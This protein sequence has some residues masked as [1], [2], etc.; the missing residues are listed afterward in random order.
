MPANLISDDLLD[1]L[2][3]AA[4]WYESQYRNAGAPARRPPAHNAPN[5]QH[6]RVT[7]PPVAYGSGYSYCQSGG[8][9]S[10]HPEWYWPAVIVLWVA[11]REEELELG[12]VWLIDFNEH[13]RE[14]RVGTRY[15]ARQCDYLCVGGDTRPVFI[16]V[17]G[18]IEAVA[19]PGTLGSNC[20][21]WSCCLEVGVVCGP[22]PDPGADPGDD[23]WLSMACPPWTFF[24]PDFGCGGSPDCGFWSCDGGDTPCANGYADYCGCSE[25][26]GIAYPFY[27]RGAGAVDLQST[28]IAIAC[29][30]A[31]FDGELYARKAHQNNVPGGPWGLRPA[32][33]A[34]DDG[35]ELHT[36]YD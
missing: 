14:L 36:T 12:K 33:L 7:G 23:S 27:G 32:L 19:P 17:G 24:D 30:F 4:E 9:R 10:H 13:E 35:R 3:A 5:W 1:R 11:G 22:N 2:R 8:G 25:P 21:V 31:C 6:A 29:M 16:T 18:G 34:D 28:G 20:P 15:A 26:P